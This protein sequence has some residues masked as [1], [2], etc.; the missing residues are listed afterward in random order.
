M[1][2]CTVLLLKK[3]YYCNAVVEITLFILH[4][5]QVSSCVETAANDIQ[6]PVEV[7]D[8]RMKPVV[9]VEMLDL[10]R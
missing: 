10:T 6:F 8:G 9:V 7:T 2:M 1:F 3:S 5:P 4:Q